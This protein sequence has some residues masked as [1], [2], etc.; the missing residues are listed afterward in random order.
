MA[1]MKGTPWQPRDGVRHKITRELS[2]PIAF[3]APAASGSP[4]REEA[5]D[6]DALVVQAAAQLEEELEPMQDAEE[7]PDLAGG[8]ADVSPV[9]TSGIRDCRSSAARARAE[10]V[11]TALSGSGMVLKLAKS[12]QWTHESIWIGGR[13]ETREG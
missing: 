12:S 11:S 3:P 4:E 2:Q 8:P 6:H 9:P 1:A 13:R 5:V 7:F 10:R